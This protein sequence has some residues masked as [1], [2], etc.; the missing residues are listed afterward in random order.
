[1]KIDGALG[2]YSTGGMQWHRKA[3]LWQWYLG[4]G[5]GV[6]YIVDD[7]L[8][9]HDFRRYEPLW[10]YTRYAREFMDLIPFGDMEPSHDL[11]SGEATY[12]KTKPRISGVVLAKPGEVYAIQLPNAT[13]TGSLDLSDAPGIFTKRWYN[14]RS[15]ADLRGRRQ[16]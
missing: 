6:E 13:S 8:N 16:Q 7:L 14:P 15:G 1:M 12:S 3:H 2:L 4:G 9:T 10:R 11:L 5:A